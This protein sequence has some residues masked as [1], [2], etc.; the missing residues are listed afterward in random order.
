MRLKIAIPI[1][2]LTIASLAVMQLAPHD[3][4]ENETAPDAGPDVVMTAIENAST[5]QAGIEG[6]NKDK[7]LSAKQ[8]PLLP[9]EETHE[10][11]ISRRTA[12][13]LDL[14]MSDD[15]A[16]L[17]AILLELDNPE[18]KVREAAVIAAVQFKSANAI[19]ALQQAYART[20]EPEEK[21]A[22]RKAIEFLE[23][24]DEASAV[25]SVR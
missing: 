4:D 11:Y 21:L 7:A 13:L 8:V 5:P 17:N 14:G 2:L 9:G 1:L 15:P 25:T 18:A 3:R 23:L 20:D 24:T 19:P 16:S 6:A 12:D 10:E 22:I